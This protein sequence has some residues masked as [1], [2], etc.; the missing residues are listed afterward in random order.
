MVMIVKAC[1]EHAMILLLVLD[2]KFS[3]WKYGSSGY[4]SIIFAAKTGMHDCPVYIVYGEWIGGFIG[5]DL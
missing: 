1:R 2:T 5:K 3:N 4:C